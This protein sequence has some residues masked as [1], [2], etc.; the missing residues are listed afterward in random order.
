MYNVV[1]LVGRVETDPVQELTKKQKVVAAWFTLSSWGAAVGNYK[2]KFNDVVAFRQT[3]QNILRHVKKGDWM[4]IV[5][6]LDSYTVFEGAK[7]VNRSVV[8]AST[9][10]FLSSEKLSGARNLGFADDLEDPVYDLAELKEY[11]DDY[12]FREGDEGNGGEE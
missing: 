2:K 3:A 1:M 11:F 8:V 9:A 6:Y 5:G 7:R 4:W 10:F 12:I